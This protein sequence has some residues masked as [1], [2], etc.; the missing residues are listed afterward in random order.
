MLIEPSKQTTGHIISDRKKFG[1]DG[2]DQISEL[3]C[4]DLSVL[5]WIIAPDANESSWVEVIIHAHQ[6]LFRRREILDLR[7]QFV[8]DRNS[9]RVLLIG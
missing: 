7:P 5:G 1:I 9:F 6:F 8:N 2:W 3:R 4:F